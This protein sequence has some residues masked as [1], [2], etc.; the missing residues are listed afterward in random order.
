MH[1]R[2]SDSGTTGVGDGRA[3]VG[4][5]AKQVADHAKRLVGLE[6]ELAM[7]ELKRKVAA[8]GT[9]I[10]MLLGA[11]VFG[12]F[13]FGFLLAALAAALDSFMPR[14]LALLIVS[15]LLLVVTGILAMVGLRAVRRGSP[16]TP[17]Q[18]ITEAK[19]TTGALKGSHG[20]T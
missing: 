11:A 14:W 9:G 10:A 8:L 20:N 19:L 16:P 4:D 3:G 17:E 6:V 13:A 7:L 1:T 2:G 12:L 18:A 5:A 15:L